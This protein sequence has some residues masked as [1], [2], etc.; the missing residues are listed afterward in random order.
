M[1]I[2]W[3]TLLEVN[4]P[5]LSSKLA[6]KLAHCLQN[7]C[8]MS[9]A[10]EA[11]NYSMGVNTLTINRKQ[12]H[13]VNQQKLINSLRNNL[14]QEKQNG[15]VFLQGG[16]GFHKYNT[17]TELVFQQESYF[18]YLFGVEMEDCF[19]SISMKTGKT[20]LFVPKL[21]D[22]Y[23]VWM[24]SIKSLTE[25][26]QIYAVDEVAYTSDM[27]QKLNSLDEEN[28][29]SMLLVNYGLN[30]DSGKYSALPQFEKMKVQFDIDQ[31]S[32]FEILTECRVIKSSEEIELIRYCNKIGSMGHVR[33][34]QNCAPDQMEYT[35]EANFMDYCYK[36]GGCRLYPYIPICGSGPNAAVL[37]Y[38]HAGAPNDRQMKDGELVLCDMGCQYYRYGSD[39]T[40]TY[41]VNG[42]FTDKQ[43]LVYEAVL[44]ANRLVIQSM[45]PGIQ[46]PDMHTLAE[47]TILSHFKKGGLVDGDVDEMVSARVGALFMPHGLGHLL[48]VDTHDVGGYPA[49]GPP[50]ISEPGL[51]SL[52]TARCL[53]EGMVI[54]VEPGCYFIPVLLQPAFENPK[55]QKYLNIDAIIQFM[56]FGGVRLE[57]N[58]LVTKDGAVSFTCVPRDVEE[59]EKVMAGG[60]WDFEKELQKRIEK[61]GF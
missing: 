3:K 18:H 7:R 58:V 13:K 15:V 10:S 26:Q 59:V 50:R 38:G 19:A 49:G 41:P 46:W 39:I 44:D 36:Q 60:E 48:G 35:I 22:E 24:G 9:T 34:M 2:S 27:I 5:Q 56:D 16:S 4:H 14:S 53:M 42:K 57:D 30:S 51:K 61:L 12:F 40:V 11:C 33:A 31:S 55:Y 23:A 37:H 32:L 20:V 54:T 8:R 43:K 52:R 29:R 28:S 1:K 17:D 47:K 25:L 45:K 6:C 21:P